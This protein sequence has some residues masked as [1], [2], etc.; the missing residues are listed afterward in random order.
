MLELLML[1]TTAFQPVTSFCSAPSRPLFGVPAD[2]LRVGRR[3]LAVQ[4]GDFGNRV[5]NSGHWRRC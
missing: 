5:A 1:T 2:A 4:L 3:D